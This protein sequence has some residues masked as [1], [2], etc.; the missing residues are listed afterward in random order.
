MS[1]V[2][3]VSQRL[4]E[5]EWPV[6]WTAPGN[7]HVTLH[8][9]GEIEPERAQLLRMALGGV[10]AQHDR[11]DLRTADLGVFPNMKRPRIIWLG[12]YGPAHRLHTLRDALG[13]VLESF[14]F[15][16]AE[17]D[18]HPHIT[19]G[20]VRDARKTRVRDLPA[21][22]RARLEQMAEKGEVTHKNPIPVPVDEVLLVQS[23]LGKDGP[24]YEVLER[25]PLRPA[26]D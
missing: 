22:I 15:E 2:D 9:L 7:A 5:E 25:Y 16:L 4:Q 26:S 21:A 1:L 3:T 23:H 18:F 12:L 17:A 14:E 19:L 6:R 20:R 11:F 24:R 10:I 13:S 8:F